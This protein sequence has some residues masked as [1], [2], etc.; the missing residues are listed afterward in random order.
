MNFMYPHDYPGSN[1]DAYSRASVLA[2]D[3]AFPLYFPITTC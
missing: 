3:I 1:V 2:L